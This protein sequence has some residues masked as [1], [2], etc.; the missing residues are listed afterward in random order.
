MNIQTVVGTL[1][2]QAVPGGVRHLV[3]SQHVDSTHRHI[4][5]HGKQFKYT[6]GVQG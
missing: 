2:V 4:I 3:E 6:I 1:Q 5:I